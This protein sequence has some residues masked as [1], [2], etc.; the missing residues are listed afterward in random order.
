[1]LFY[2]FY[3]KFKLNVLRKLFVVSFNNSS[4]ISIK[5]YSV[6]RTKLRKF[7][8]LLGY[9]TL[10]III[11]KN[12][13]FDEIILCQL[14]IK[15]INCAFNFFSCQRSPTVYSVKEIFVA[16]CDGFISE[17][18]FFKSSSI[19]IWVGTVAITTAPFSLYL[20]Q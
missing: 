18:C 1:M 5:Q 10:C 19:I 13:A 15:Q 3:L 17:A 14:E 4:I 8:V 16:E 9:C 7:C 6:I 2:C 20:L 12:N 11:I